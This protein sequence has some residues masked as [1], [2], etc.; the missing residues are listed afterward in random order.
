LSS[1]LSSIFNE[2][3]LIT[4][5]KSLANKLDIPAENAKFK[6]ILGKDYGRFRQ[7]MNIVLEAS[8]SASG[9][10]GILMLR[11]AEAGG[12]RGIA[13][14]LASAATAGGAAAAGFV[15]PAPV[16]AAGAAALFIP[17]IFAKIATNPA[18]INRLIALT[19][20]KSQG[21]EATSVAAQLL[22]ADVFYSMADEEKNEM[23]RYLSEVAKQGME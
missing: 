22:V 19:G 3:F 7:T 12:V 10:F 5:L 23:M 1:R 18:Y 9:D 4:D 17:Q 16:L 20:K 6:Y 8:E 2:K 11:S 14:Q 13:G 21:V 15:S